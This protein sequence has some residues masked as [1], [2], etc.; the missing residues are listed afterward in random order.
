MRFLAAYRC[1]VRAYRK[2]THSSRAGQGRA[3]GRKAQLDVGSNLADQAEG[4]EGL[5][6][7]GQR[8]AW[9]GNAQYGHLRD[10]AGDGE[11]FLR[12][13]LGGQPFGNDTGAAFIRAVILA[14]TIVALDVAGRRHRHMH[15]GVMMVGLF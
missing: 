5:L 8:I 6:R 11:H 4:F 14:V 7:I 15:T 10:G 12:G 2:S 1:G 13:L 9:P 3:V